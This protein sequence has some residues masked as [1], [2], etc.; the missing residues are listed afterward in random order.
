M[1][2]GRQKDLPGIER[3]SIPEI[4]AAAEAYVKARDKRMELTKEE[5]ATH[6]ALAETMKRHKVKVYKDS[7]ADPPLIMTL[8]ST[9]VVVKVKVSVAPKDPEPAAD[10]EKNARADRTAR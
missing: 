2:R 6:E 4:N 1:A 8:T 3:E 5:V 7:D 9:E 10:G